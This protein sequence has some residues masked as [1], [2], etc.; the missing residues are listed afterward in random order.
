FA[1]RAFG[2][3]W[4]FDGTAANPTLGVTKSDVNQTFNQQIW[5]ATGLARLDLVTTRSYSS[6]T[7]M[8]G[9]YDSPVGGIAKSWSRAISITNYEDAYL[10]SG[11]VNPTHAPV[12]TDAYGESYDGLRAYTRSRST[13]QFDLGLWSKFGK[14]LLAWTKSES[15]SSNKDEKTG[16]L[17]DGG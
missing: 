9:S 8:N 2:W 10:P 4:S 1:P 5:Q 13:Q 12:V 14:T 16:S 15:W 7:D 11:S 17:S 6:D 3:S